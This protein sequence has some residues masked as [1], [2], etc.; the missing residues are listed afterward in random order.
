VPVAYKQMAV[1][2]LADGRVEPNDRLPAGVL[3]EVNRRRNL[4]GLAPHG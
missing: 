2:A 4:I 1:D 3:E